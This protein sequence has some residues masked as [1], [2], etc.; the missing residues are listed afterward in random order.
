MVNCELSR[1]TIHQAPHLTTDHLLF[2]ALDDY[3][4]ATRD[5][6]FRRD[7]GDQAA[8]R[9][10]DARTPPLRAAARGHG[11][12]GRPPL[13]RRRGRSDEGVGEALRRE[14]GE[15]PRLLRH[16]PRVH[17]RLPAR[18]RV[19]GLAGRRVGAEGGGRRQRAGRAL[20]VAQLARRLHAQEAGHHAARHPQLPRARHLEGRGGGAGRLRG[21]GRGRGLRVGA[22]RARPLESL[23]HRPRRARRRGEDRPAHRPRGGGRAHDSSPLPA[24]QEQP[25]LRRR[26]RRRQDRHRRGARPQDSAGRGARPAQG[27]RGLLARHGRAPRGHEVPR[28]VRA[29]A[30]GRHRRAQEEG[31]RHPLHRR[32]PHHRRRGRRLR[33]LDGRLEHHQAGARLRRDALHRLDDLSGIQGRVR[34]RPRAGAALPE[35]RGLRSPRSKTRSRFSKG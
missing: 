31:E 28:R 23:R 11:G 24:A 16:A 8:A 1:A 13:R 26:P 15:R 33:R 10:R 20:P 6:E 2:T 25:H 4:R 30:Q 32:D 9:V 12:A 14:D 3:Q 35:D 19:R 18:R 29:A 5:P 22:G 17:G 21:R 27:R 7:G 34:A